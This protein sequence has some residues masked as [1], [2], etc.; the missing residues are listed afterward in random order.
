MSDSVS[1]RTRE[2]GIR[3]ALG[4]GARRVVSLVLR[5][6]LRLVFVG[7]AVGALA[8]YGAGQLI[9]SPIRARDCCGR[10]QAY[11]THSV[12][13]ESISQR[14]DGGAIGG[15]NLVER[16]GNALVAADP[17]PEFSS[18]YRGLGPYMGHHGEGGAGCERTL[19]KFAL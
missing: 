9:A 17:P 7:V 18:G 11:S 1:Q 8:S 12:L 2:R 15:R 5:D 16:H 3:L 19:G 4:A 14:I 13:A 10:Q 6:G